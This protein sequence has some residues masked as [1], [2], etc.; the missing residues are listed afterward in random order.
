VFAFE[1]TSQTFERLSANVRLNQFSN[2]SLHRMA[3]SDEEREMEI[4][5]SMDGYDGWNSFAKPCVGKTISS[6]KVPAVT[7]DSFSEQNGLN[8]RV[9][10][11]KIDVEGWEAFVLRGGKKLLARPDAPLLQVEFTDDAAAA[12]GGSCQELYRM[13]ETLKYQMFS[14]DAVANRLLPAPIR[15]KYPYLNL[16]AVKDLQAVNRRLLGQAGP[17]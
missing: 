10:M 4:H 5:R 8:G 9:A 12:A 15:E 7:W 16:F 17:G 14:F 13:L 11:M 2:T 1:P 3:L 6:E